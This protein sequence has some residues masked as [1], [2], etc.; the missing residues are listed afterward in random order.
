MKNNETEF[1]EL[2]FKHLFHAA[3][4]LPLFDPV[5]NVLR[6]QIAPRFTDAPSA[7]ARPNYLKVH[8]FCDEVSSPSIL[9]LASPRTATCR[10]QTSLST[11]Y[12]SKRQ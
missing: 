3:D 12:Y 11:H 8:P 5:Q 10:G 4:K 2:N 6:Q 9:P 1:P 7:A